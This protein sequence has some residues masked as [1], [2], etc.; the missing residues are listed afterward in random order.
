MTRDFYDADPDSR[1]FLEHADRTLGIALS[2]ICFDGPED[3]LRQTE[4]TQPA[5]FV[6]SI[7]VAR[8]IRHLKPDMVA[9]HSLG[10][11]SA[12]VVAGAL[13]FED[14][15]RLVRLRG[16]LMQKSGIEHKGT[17]AAIVGLDPALLEEICREASLVGVVQ[18]ANFNSPGQ[19]AISGSN[20]G[21]QRAIALARASGA[22]MAK[23]L[24]VSGAFHSPL[25]EG[26][27]E[28]LKQGLARAE[29]R[30]A[31]IPVYANVTGEPVIRAAEIR[32]LLYQ[33]LTSPVRW[34]Q[35]M[36][37]MARDGADMFCELGPGKV[38]QGL[39][40]RTVEGVRMEGYDKLKEIP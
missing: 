33:Q 13:G 27:R 35:S 6:H 31:S 37:N 11:Y 14:G 15:L 4:Y 22:K 21:V 38:L 39:V 29:I 1:A 40:K 32:E 26:A 24:V 28:G 8:R 19:V 5:I 9:G 34:E 3:T 16:Q 20:D 10:E 12:L 23:E 2:A 25:M 36:K 17:M 7:L 30:D 18:P